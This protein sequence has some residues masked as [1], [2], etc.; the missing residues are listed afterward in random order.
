MVMSL[1]DA[2]EVLGVPPTANEVEIKR[3][4]RAL[5]R[6]YHPDVS[7]GEGDDARFREARRAYEELID[8]EARARR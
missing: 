3:A 5:A 4:F 2:Y 6:K 8:R 1:G 7:P